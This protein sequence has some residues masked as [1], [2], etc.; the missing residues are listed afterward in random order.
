ML[1]LKKYLFMGLLMA[2]VAMLVPSCTVEDDDPIDY[3]ISI[4]GGT[5]T[6]GGTTYTA[7]QT[8]IL[9]VGDQ[10]NISAGTAPAGKAFDNWTVLPAGAVR[11]ANANNSNT[12]ITVND[13]W[14]IGTKVTITANFATSDVD[15]MIRYTWPQSENS[16]IEYVEAGE[17]MINWWY[18]NIWGDSDI[19]IEDFSDE[20]RN[21][22]NP[23]IN[24]SIFKKGGTPNNYG[25]YY[26]IDAGSYTAVCSVSDPNPALDVIWEIVANYKINYS[27]SPASDAFF[28]LGFDVIEYLDGN[29]DTGFKFTYG[30]ENRNKLFKAKTLKKKLESNGVTMDVTYYVFARA[31]K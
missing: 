17:S 3:N 18:E 29:T 23:Y 13:G 14:G 21:D 9:Y 2:A 19:D 12:A 28:D 8:I 7:S 1:K 16:L 24:G 22:G 31:R 11:F 30:A 5:L 10:A 26:Y 25:N 15:V 20:P 4:V 27:T 6:F